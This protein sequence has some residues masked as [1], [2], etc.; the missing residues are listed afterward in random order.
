MSR[1]GYIV[2]LPLHVNPRGDGI[3]PV[4]CLT[5]ASMRSEAD[6]L[7]TNMPPD[8]QAEFNTTVRKAIARF[9]MEGSE[10]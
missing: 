7:L 1:W 5:I 8:V 2:G 9:L 6:T 4:G 3:L 10:P